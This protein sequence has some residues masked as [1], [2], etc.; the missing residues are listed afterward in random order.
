MGIGSSI[1][2]G[3]CTDGILLSSI[4]EFIDDYCDGIDN[5]KGL[6]TEYIHK[7]YLKPITK[8]SK[9]SYCQYL[10]NSSTFH[11]N[12]V[13][14]ALVYV[15]HTWEYEFLYVIDALNYF[16]TSN[17]NTNKFEKNQDVYIFIDI[18]SRN[19]HI[20]SSSLSDDY[21][22]KS[23][24]LSIKDIG[25]TLMVCSPYTDSLTFKNTMNL[26]E[27]YCTGINICI[28]LL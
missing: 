16:I 10:K 1:A 15:S 9:T 21:L 26:F 3:D 18:F 23:V 27:L 19:P 25:H 13:G 7:K 22:T 2:H 28:L 24:L 4:V 5:I 17:Y 6:T 11:N 12:N 14:K 20:V 8:R